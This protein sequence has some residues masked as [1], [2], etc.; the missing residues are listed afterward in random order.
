[1][2]K[3][4]VEM[5]RGLIAV[6]KGDYRVVIEKDA[7]TIVDPRSGIDGGEVF[8]LAGMRLYQEHRNGRSW[9]EMLLSVVRNMEPV[10]EADKR[11]G[12]TT[13]EA[14]VEDDDL[15]PI[16]GE[17]CPDEYDWQDPGT[18]NPFAIGMPPGEA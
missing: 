8:A 9:G 6:V 13:A 3:K 11:D 15:C 16:H 2:Y 12:K 10:L 18:Y 14:R 4:A 7:I 1:M 17:D 5:M